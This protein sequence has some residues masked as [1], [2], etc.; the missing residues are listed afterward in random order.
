MDKLHKSLSEIMTQIA[1]LG[2]TAPAADLS[3]S[4]T[5]LGDLEKVLRKKRVAWMA[6]LIRAAGQGELSGD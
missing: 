1:A 6:S 2:E 4:L 3:A 5:I